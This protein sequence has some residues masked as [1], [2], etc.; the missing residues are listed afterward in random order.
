MFLDPGSEK[1][2]TAKTPLQWR[3]LT[4]TE[5]NR[6]WKEVCNEVEER[7]WR[8]ELKKERGECEGRGDEPQWLIK[9]VD[10][11]EKEGDM[12]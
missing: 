5:T 6:Q 3:N 11:H 1:K 8:K 7:C 12:R 9:K 4:H 2:N 10:K